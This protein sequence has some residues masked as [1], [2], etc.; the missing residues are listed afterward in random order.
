MVAETIS[1]G[2]LSLPAT[3]SQL[4][5][6][7]GLIIMVGMGILASYNGYVIGQIKWRFPHISSMS[8]AGEVLL[9]A[10][11]REFL[12]VIQLL[13]LIFIMASHILTFT[14]AFNVMTNH[15]ICSI[16][17]GIIATALS[18]ILSFPRTLKNMSWLSIICECDGL[19]D[20]VASH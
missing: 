14:V 12:G 10:F 15:A 1:L 5:L 8:D 3:V 11:G 13:L 17:F 18:L 20:K 4:G 19:I 16:A 2:I 6:V 7:P 9:G